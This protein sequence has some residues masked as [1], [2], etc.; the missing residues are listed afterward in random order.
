MIIP[1][2]AADKKRLLCKSKSE[3][4]LL[5]MFGRVS[6]LSPSLWFTIPWKIA[7]PI[8]KPPPGPSPGYLT[9]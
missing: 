7:W 8:N 2:V 9:P 1:Q 4:E 6:Q 3:E 5:L